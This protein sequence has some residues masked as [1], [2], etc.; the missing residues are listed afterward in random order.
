VR[1]DGICL[2][3]RLFHVTLEISRTVPWYRNVTPGT[4]TAVWARVAGWAGE[5][6]KQTYC[7]YAYRL[8]F[9]TCDMYK[10]SLRHIRVHDPVLSSLK[11]EGILFVSCVKRSDL[12]LQVG[13]VSK[14]YIKLREKT[15]SCTKTWKMCTEW[16]PESCANLPMVPAFS[17]RQKIIS[18]QSS[19]RPNS[20]RSV[21]W[22]CG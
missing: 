17:K 19:S 9:L 7:C 3:R 22:I 13:A 12:E 1:V 18:A 15:P 16:L 21:Q 6:E 8:Y 14:F 4:L 10:S 11:M 20:F 2:R 5:E